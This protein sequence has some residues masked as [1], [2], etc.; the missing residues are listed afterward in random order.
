MTAV[1]VYRNRPKGCWSVVSAGKVSQHL[2]SLLLKDCKFHVQPAGHGRYLREKVRNVH[3]YVS[4][5][6]AKDCEQ[7]ALDGVWLRAFY[8]L[9]EGRFVLVDDTHLLTASF[10]RFNADGSIHIQF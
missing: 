10:V 5:H 3:A 7:G 6:I 9:D 1:K 4:G 2:P 8:R